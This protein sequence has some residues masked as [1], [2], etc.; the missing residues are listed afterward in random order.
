MSFL[1][2]MTRKLWGDIDPDEMRRFAFLGF[3]LMIIIGN[4]WMLSANKNAIFRMFVDFRKYQPWVKVVSVFLMLLLVSVYGKLV[5]VFGQ[6]RLSDILGVFFG[7]WLLGLSFFLAY[8]KLVFIDE[9]SH[10]Y[11][12]VS[13]IPGR[14]LGW[15]GY[16]SVE[17]LIL[18]LTL[19]WAIVAS[20]TV[21]ESAKKGYG[22]IMFLA[23][24]GT[25]GGAAFTVNYVERIGIPFVVMLGGILVLIVPFLIRAYLKI[26]SRHKSGDAMAV[27][28]KEK[29]SCM[30][31][32]Y[33]IVTKPY[34][35]GVFII[36]SI[37]EIVR[38]ILEY[39]M[40]NFASIVY[41]GH[42]KFAV[43]GGWFAMGVNSVTLLF[44]FFGTSFFMR[45]LG[46]RFC[47]VVL[48][49]AMGVVVSS[50]FCF[51]FVL[52][53]GSYGLMWILFVGMVCVRG[54]NYAINKPTK[55]VMYIPTSRDVKFKAKSWISAFGSRLTKAMGAG[56]NVTFSQSLSQ[57]MVFG[58]LVSL[59]I[60]GVWIFIAVLLGSKFVE[61]QEKNSVVE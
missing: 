51:R 27:K 61:L 21:T 3:I 56:V 20:T 31:G 17:S 47:L 50:V 60:V 14:L 10:L 8:P 7:A 19:F 49:V 46:L 53:I 55:E 5:D 44:S 34:V 16:L 23:Q 18:L 1:P 24:I 28:K 15:V 25:V 38:T 45:R 12:Y 39:Q 59:S 26:P 58:T 40:Y 41:P 11:P 9:R 36:S 33:L 35:M 2:K 4:Y 13:W 43:F 30:E 48:P 22:L 29:T 57:L 42:E 37:G 52:G 54:L 32:L 6:K